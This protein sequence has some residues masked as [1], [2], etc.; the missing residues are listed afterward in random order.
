MFKAD[1]VCRPFSMYDGTIRP[2]RG[3]VSGS[4]EWCHRAQI[5][6]GSPG[7]GMVPEKGRQRY[8]IEL[9]VFLTEWL[10]GEVEVEGGQLD[11]CLLV[12]WV[13]GGRG[14]CCLFS[15]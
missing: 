8:V 15:G 4:P 10:S 11:V 13:L 9:K 7:V 5:R 3:T 12:C 2:L 1:L 14:V 6:R